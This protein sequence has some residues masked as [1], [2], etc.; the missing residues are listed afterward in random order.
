[1]PKDTRTRQEKGNDLYLEHK[2]KGNKT[3]G[4]LVDGSN[5]NKYVVMFNDE[6]GDEAECNCTDFQVRRTACKHIIA[7]QLLNEQQQRDGPQEQES[8]CSAR[9]QIWM[10]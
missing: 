9:I 6:N 1:M 5:G 2:V 10:G 8:S 7:S 3:D 4:F